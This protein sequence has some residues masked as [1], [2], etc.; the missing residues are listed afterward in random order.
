MESGEEAED[1]GED[2]EGAEE[3]E[4]E[5]PKGEV[6]QDYSKDADNFSDGSSSDKDSD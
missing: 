1:D 4:P 6:D 5:L 3:E 2:S